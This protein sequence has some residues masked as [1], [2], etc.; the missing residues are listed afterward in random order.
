MPTKLLLLVSLVASI[1]AAPLQDTL[2]NRLQTEDAATPEELV[3][4]PTKDSSTIP[5]DIQEE[6]FRNPRNLQGEYNRQ[7]SPE[8][9]SVDGVVAEEAK[10][11]SSK[12]GRKH[13]AFFIDYP[14]VPQIPSFPS[15]DNYD[16]LETEGRTPGNRKRYQESNIYY[17]RLP[18]TP[19]MFVPGLG[20]ISQPPT[21]STAPLRPQLAPLRPYRPQSIYQPSIN[22]F[23]N[24]PIDFVS[25]GKP[26]SVYQWQSSAFKPSKRPES[27]VANLDK[28][29]YFFN[30]RPTSLYLLRPDGQS[31]V[32]QPIQYPDYQDN[33]YY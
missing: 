11:K 32:H 3:V 8:L 10:T 25:N 30:G 14:Y 19:Y 33:N 29:P 9:E 23:I 15:Y 31:S 7:S 27:Q 18:P 2:D 24:L 12:K 6:D 26:T 20:Y 13:K 17:I 22:P 16:D 4:S 28:G 1:T 5:K 21:Y